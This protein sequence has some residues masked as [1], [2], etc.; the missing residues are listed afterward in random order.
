[1]TDRPMSKRMQDVLATIADA[2]SGEIRGWS[3]ATWLLQRQH[4]EGIRESLRA[5]VNRGLIAM[6][7]MDDT[8][9][10]WQKAFPDRL[11]AMYS[12]AKQDGPEVQVG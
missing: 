11:K 6:R 7:P 2:K 12:I 9:D 5:L 8:R 4:P 10:E 1:M 3:I